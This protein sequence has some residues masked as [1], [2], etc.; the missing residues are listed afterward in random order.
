[1]NE[2]LISRAVRR[3]FAGG[4]VIGLTLLALPGQVLGQEAAPRPAPQEAQPVQRVQ[5]TGSLIRRSQAETSQEV[6][7]VNRA[8]IEKS[9]KAT[10]AELLQTLAVDNQG[11]VPTSFGNGFAPG[12]SGISLRGLGVASTLVLI[13]GRRTAPYGLSDDGQKQFTDL[14][15]IPTDAVDRVE[16]LLEGA[17]SIYGSDAIAGVVNVILR[18]GYNGQTIRASEGI[19]DYWDG[20]QAT[21]AWT[22]GHGDLDSDKYNFVLSA[23][24]KKTDNANCRDRRDRS[25]VCRLDLRHWG[26]SAQESLAG[27][28]AI[29]SNNTA[30]SAINGNVRNPATLDYANRGSVDPATGFTRFFPG[31]NCLNFTRH[32]QGDPGGGC[33]IDA[34]LEYNQVQPKTESISLYGRGAWQFHPQHQAFTELLYYTNATDTVTTPSIISANEGSPAGAVSNAS[35]ALGAAHPDNP[36]FGTPARLR[37]L[38]ADVGP[39]KNHIDSNF[40]RWMGGLKG[41]LFGWDYDST[42]LWSHNNVWNHYRGYLERNA[43]FALLDPSAV[44]VAAATAANPA[45]AALPPGSLWRIGENAGLNSPAVYAALSPTI[46][47]RSTTE[48][49]LIDFKATRD[50]AGLL[51][52][53]ALGL[54]VGGEFRHEFSEL[55]PVTGTSTGNIIGLGFSAYKGSHNVSALYTEALAPLPYKVELTGAIRW[56]RYTDVG[57][58]WTPKGGLKWTPIRE[59]AVRGTYARGFRAPS[60]AENGVGGLAAFATADDPVRCALGVAVACNPAPIALVTRSNPNLSPEH[61]SS[62][63]VG[64]IWDPIPRASVSVDVWRIKRR[65]EINQQQVSQAIAT[66]NVVR[67]PSTALPGVPGD[68]GAIAVVNSQFVNSSQSVVKGIDLDARYSYVLPK[69]YGTVS[70]DGK[71]THMFRW[72][73]TEK[74]G[75]TIDFAGTHGNCDVTNCAGTPRNK[76]NMHLNYER[77]KWRTT[78]TVNYRSSFK[79]VLFQ[80]DPGGCATTFADGTPAPRDCEIASFITFDLAVRWKPLPKWEVFGYVENL[81]SKV[82]PLDPLTYGAQSYNPNDF[83]GARGRM[84]TLGARYTF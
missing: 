54:A 30:G 53:G 49:A 60:P 79:N 57:S 40:V 17:S 10:V 73:R 5:V 62:W 27:T 55:D 83:S 52:W 8:D 51:P 75:T 6:L 61:A 38:A 63:D 82:A 65:D 68:P 2:T 56:D 36:Y 39:R 4:G 12:A 74:D 67:D 80:G 58:A 78:V 28:G 1:M 48:L 26:F 84:Y 70:A 13:N 29:I 21:A 32:P 64:V 45:Y 47:S 19:T 23:E 20:N 43:T 14:N 24:Y 37:Y 3:L 76:A 22:F 35:V 66:G 33:L 18:Q 69:G 46:S 44:N 59:L 15:I 34:P 72:A 9:G 16:I 11:S 7:T 50:F 81:T 25:Q 41:T 71:L 31:A 77:D 42:L